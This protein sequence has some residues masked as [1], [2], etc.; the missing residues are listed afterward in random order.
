MVELELPGVEGGSSE[1]PQKDGG[2]AA[3]QMKG[4]NSSTVGGIAE[5]GVTRGSEVDT[6]LMGPPGSGNKP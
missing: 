1:G 2:L 6:E 4:P 3:P 5:D